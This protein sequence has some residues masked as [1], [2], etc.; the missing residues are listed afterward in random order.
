MFNNFFYQM[1]TI[2]YSVFF[3][4][5]LACSNSKNET[6]ATISTISSK[7][8]MAD[9]LDVAELLKDTQAYDGKQVAITGTVVH[10]CKHS[11]KRMHL[12]G[13]DETTKVRVEAGD[14]G[15]FDRE[16]EGSEIVAV[17][18]FHREVIDEDY[19]AKWSGEL[20]KEG[21]KEHKSTVEQA[22][23]KGQI[24]Q[25][26]QMMKTTEDGHLENIWVEGISFEPISAL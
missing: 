2:F 5:L 1:K 10:V 8:E 7:S 19:L 24:E 16:L 22:E 18:V 17:G 11:G 4:A 12:L 9:V 25:Y 3:L 26:R 13:K 14:I 20:E 21:M 23:E 15:Q 6:N